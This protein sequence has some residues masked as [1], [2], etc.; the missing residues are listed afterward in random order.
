MIKVIDIYS[1]TLMLNNTAYKY[2]RTAQAT[3]SPIADRL[4]HTQ[5]L[6]P[7]RSISEVASNGYTNALMPSQHSPEAR[8]ARDIISSRMRTD[9]NNLM[10]KYSRAKEA[11]TGFDAVLAEAAQN[12]ASNRIKTAPDPVFSR[13]DELRLS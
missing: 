4:T 11:M 13:T 3:E 1:Q 2:S 10:Y 6:Q 9:S 12:V 7:D 8:N 5:T